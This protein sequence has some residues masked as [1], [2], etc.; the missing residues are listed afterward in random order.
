[1]ELAKEFIRRPGLWLRFRG[2]F[3]DPPDLPMDDPSAA[4]T[5]YARWIIEKYESDPLHAV[6]VERILEDYNDAIHEAMERD[7]RDPRGR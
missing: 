2:K 4:A 7:R 6:T 1:L 3:G 5:I